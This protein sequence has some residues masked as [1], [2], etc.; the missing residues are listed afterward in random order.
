MGVR[1][2]M[3][4]KQRKE[5]PALSYLGFPGAVPELDNHKFM[6]RLG[7]GDAGTLIDIIWRQTSHRIANLPDM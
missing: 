5:I 6:M 4:T 7:S 1:D 2:Y 3:V